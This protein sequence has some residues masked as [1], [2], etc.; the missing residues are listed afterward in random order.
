VQSYLLKIDE[1]LD[2]YK[3]AVLDILH[4]A[5]M[6]LFGELA[7]N[8]SIDISAEITA[9]IRFLVNNFQDIFGVKDDGNAKAIG[10]NLDEALV[11]GEFVSKDI[12]K[13]RADDFLLE[14]LS[15]I[16]VSPAY[17]DSTG[18]SD[19][20]NV[21]DLAKN[22]GDPN[23]GP[24]AELGYFLEDYTPAF[25][26]YFL[27]TDSFTYVFTYELPINNISILDS[28]TIINLDYDTGTYFAE[29][30]AGTITTF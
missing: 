11:A 3:K 22:I 7:L 4:P 30:Y 5:G 13:I 6:K 23:A 20:G 27:V 28:G 1:R 25:Y 26:E 21:K 10:K 18:T 14:D 12:T 17:E 8:A 29:E 24:Y 15:A 16:L 9:T 2:L 19:D